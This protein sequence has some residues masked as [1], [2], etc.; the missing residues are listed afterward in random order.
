[1]ISKIFNL[2]EC[3]TQLDESDH[4]QSFLLL[5]IIRS[6][7]CVYKMCSLLKQKTVIVCGN[8]ASVSEVC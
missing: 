2:H 4:T 6:T 3:L 5:A 7:A 1:M 8:L